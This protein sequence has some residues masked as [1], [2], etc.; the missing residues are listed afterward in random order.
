MQC[1]SICQTYSY[2]HVM[3]C[4]QMSST[5]LRRGNKLELNTAKGHTHWK[6][7]H[8]TPQSPILYAY[9]PRRMP[10]L[11]SLASI[12]LKSQVDLQGFILQVTAPIDGDHPPLRISLV[13]LRD[14]AALQA[15]SASAPHPPPLHHPTILAEPYCG[16][17]LLL[18]RWVCSRQGT[19]MLQLHMCSTESDASSVQSRAEG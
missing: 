19:G 1:G 13:I 11:G 8:P 3:K 10:R 16:L 12:P 14:R 9:T 4:K 18:T 2:R 7:F 5:V 6:A 17:L 15:W